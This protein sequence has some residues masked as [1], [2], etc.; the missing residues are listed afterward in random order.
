[1][2][3]QNPEINIIAMWEKRIKSYIWKKN[4][5]MY[6]CVFYLPQQNV[7]MISLLYGYLLVFL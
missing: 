5:F 2:N 1:M 4:K 6:V 7:N 3:K